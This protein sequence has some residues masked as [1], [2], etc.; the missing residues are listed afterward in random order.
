VLPA[1]DKKEPLRWTGASCTSEGIAVLNDHSQ[2]CTELN[3]P[4]Q[5][6]FRRLKKKFS[7]FDSD[8]KGQPRS[9]LRDRGHP[10]AKLGRSFYDPHAVERPV[11]EDK[12][13]REED[14]GQDMGERRAL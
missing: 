9:K 10:G 2:G 3:P 7:I 12:R 1:A 14:D 4:F 8:P 13:N 6:K 11:H 5:G